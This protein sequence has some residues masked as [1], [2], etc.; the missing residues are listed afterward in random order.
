MSLK[1]MFCTI[2]INGIYECVKEIINDPLSREGIIFY[3]YILNKIHT[4][5]ENASKSGILFNCEEVP[6]ESLANK[7][8]LK[9]NLLHNMTYDIYSNQFVPL[10][11]DVDIHKRISFEGQFSKY[12]SGGCITHINM[13]EQIT[14]IEQMRE[15]MLYIIKS[16]VEHYAINY[17]FCICEE[18]H[19]TTNKPNCLCKVC[20]KPVHEYTRIIG[21]FVPVQQFS[22]GRKKEHGT[23]IFY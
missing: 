20:N 19:V 4:Y 14:T 23:R 15:L 12:L 6:A 9:D 10:S 16:G 5:A 17:N 18:H 8:A 2:G 11:C 7:F 22:S 1:R 21:Y 13:I 3:K